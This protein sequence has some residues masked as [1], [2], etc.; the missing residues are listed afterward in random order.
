MEPKELENKEY[1]SLRQE[2]LEDMKMQV[3]L[4]TIGLTLTISVWA[5]GAKW[6]V[7]ADKSYIFLISLAPLFFFQLLIFRRARSSNRKVAYIIRF[8]EEENSGWEKR[9]DTLREST[10][11]KEWLYSLRSYFYMC[12]L[13]FLLEVVTIVLSYP[14]L[15]KCT[16]ITL[17]LCIFIGCLW[18]YTLLLFISLGKSRENSVRGFYEKWKRL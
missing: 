7:G 8:F 6:F 13:Y 2:I 16:A 17:P 5:I 10:R 18:L 1:K 11:G 12:V 4:F 3:H 15:K 14:F 9:L